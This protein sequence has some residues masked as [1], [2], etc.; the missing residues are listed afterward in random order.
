MSSHGR[1][2][3]AAARFIESF[4]G[5]MVDSGMPRMAARIFAYLLAADDG[6]ATAAELAERLQAS[7]AAVSGGVRY[8]AQVH[9]VLRERRPGQRKD[10]YTLAHDLWYESLGTRDQELNRWAVVARRGVEAVGE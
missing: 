4:A 5:V 8:L 10:T 3:D 2:D 1:D 9:L 7:P 6:S